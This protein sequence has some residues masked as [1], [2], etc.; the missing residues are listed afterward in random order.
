[1]TAGSLRIALTLPGAVSLGAYEA[2][3]LAALLVGTQ[4]LNRR[5]RGALIVD[6]VAGASAGSITG[7]VAARIVLAGQRPVPVL[8]RLWVD[9]PSLRNLRGRGLRS[10]MSVGRLREVS[11]ELI[12]LPGIDAAAQPSEV[13]LNLALGALRGLEYRLEH[14]NGPDVRATTYLDWR[15]HTLPAGAGP[16][17]FFEPLR[18]SLADFAEASGA[19]PAVFAPVR[20]DR[21]A[22]RALYTRVRNFPPSGCFWYTDGGV[23]D[24]EPLGRALDAANELDAE[25]PGSRRLHLV[26]SPSPAVPARGDDEWSDPART[27]G[28]SRTIARTIEIMR[29]QNLFDDL[30][31]LD[32]TNQR[33]ARLRRL[34]A[35]LATG[36][37]PEGDDPDGPDVAFDAAAVNAPPEDEAAAQ[38][39]RRL[40]HAAGLTGK[41]AVE[42][43]VVSPLVLPEVRAGRAVARVLAGDFLF[44]FGGFLDRRHRSNDFAAGYRSMLVWMSSPT[45][46]LAAR[47]L[48]PGLAEAACRAAGGYDPAAWESEPA[49]A[50]MRARDWPGLAPPVVR[51]AAVW[52]AERL[53]RPVP[54]GR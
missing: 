17:D 6:T 44:H 15:S 11:E 37:E 1:M 30:R 2:G 34:E 26:I 50:R 12:G 35:W 39:R 53:R 46:G 19:N 43:D 18:S 27:P 4:E 38:R 40:E 24:N 3:A 29:A 21:S 33:L 28:W 20:I 16:A 23:L 48:E 22:D 7:V 49:D 51:A 25:D 36:A 54:R 52:A 5:K 42:A 9:A 14:L 41:R 8:R 45:R 13:R 31:R 32:K 47:G 10:P